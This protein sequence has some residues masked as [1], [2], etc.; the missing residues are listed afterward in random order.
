[1]RGIR[2]AVGEIRERGVSEWESA[3]VSLF[4]GETW[5]GNVDRETCDMTCRL[6]SRFN[7]S[8]LQVT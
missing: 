7:E 4:C 2:F 8:V 6:T 5:D 1:M 3:E